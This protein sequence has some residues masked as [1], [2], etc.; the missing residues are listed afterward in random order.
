MRNK[1]VEASMDP[2]DA[3]EYGDALTER[4]DVCGTPVEGERGEEWCV[5]CAAPAGD[6][7]REDPDR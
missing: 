7:V 2:L 3:Y 4:C 6:S 1:A 5:R